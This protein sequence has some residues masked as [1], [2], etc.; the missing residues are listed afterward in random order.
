MSKKQTLDMTQG[1][2]LTLLVKFAI[3]LVLG[4]IFQ[5]LYSFVDTA[6]VG[7]CIGVDALSA[8]GVTGALNFS[9]SWTYNGACFVHLEIQRDRFIFCWFRVA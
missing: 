1:N 8:V 4:S 7:R 2:P 9:C 3:P 6:I 5:Q